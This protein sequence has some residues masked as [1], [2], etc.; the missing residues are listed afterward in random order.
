[1]FRNE[2]ISLYIDRSVIS[3]KMTEPG[4]PNSFLMGFD[5]RVQYIGTALITYINILKRIINAVNA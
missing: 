3:V 5:Q 1:M 4:S 2:I